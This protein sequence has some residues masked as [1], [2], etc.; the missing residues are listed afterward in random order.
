VDPNNP[1]VTEWFAD[2]KYV[3]PDTSKLT[4]EVA[5][6]PEPGRYDF[7]LDPAPRQKKPA[8]L[9]TGL[10]GNVDKDAKKEGTGA[11]K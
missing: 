2:Q 11:K 1:Y 9:G 10:E 6:N 3:Y 4:M 7:Q 5:E 8:F